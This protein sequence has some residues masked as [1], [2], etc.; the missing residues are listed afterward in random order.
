MIG[1]WFLA[2]D[3]RTTGETSIGDSVFL[4]KEVQIPL[5]VNYAKEA[6]QK[7]KTV[8]SDI[9]QAVKDADKEFF[10]WHFNVV[11]GEDVMAVSNFRL[12]FEGVIDVPELTIIGGP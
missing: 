2:F 7:A 6:E 8:I 12:C 3:I 9:R 5:Y 1:K 11:E 10:R 4:R